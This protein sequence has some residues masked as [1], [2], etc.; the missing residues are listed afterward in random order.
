MGEKNTGWHVLAEDELPELQRFV[1]E[2]PEYWHV[3]MGRD[4]PPDAA[5]QIFDD[6]PPREWAWSGT[7]VAVL[8]D[9]GGRMAAIASITEGLFKPPIWHV[10]LFIAAR[11]LHGTGAS[12]EAYASLER[13]M[14]GSG[15]EWVRLG[16]VVGNARAERFW[17]KMGFVEVRRRH[18]IEVEGRACDLRVMVKA[19]GGGRL[20]DYLADVERDRPDQ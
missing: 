5:R 4:P 19:L 8:R 6:R 10:G 7:C 11:R 9:A 1:E 13:W 17:E 14:R 15:A 20:A 16:V 2:N 18:D 12:G 3:V